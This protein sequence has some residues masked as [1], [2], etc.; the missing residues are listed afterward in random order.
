[1]ENGKS[2]IAPMEYTF[3]IYS[4]DGEGMVFI[5]VVFRSGNRHGERL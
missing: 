1:M 4:L 3:T 2:S 5:K